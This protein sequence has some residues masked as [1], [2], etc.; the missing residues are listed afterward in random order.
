MTIIDVKAVWRA[1]DD[2]VSGF[3]LDVIGQSLGV[4][5]IRRRFWPDELDCSFR[6][7]CQIAFLEKY[8]LKGLSMKENDE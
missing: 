2:G 6:R 1:L 8:T 7:R 4:T 3:S 5:R